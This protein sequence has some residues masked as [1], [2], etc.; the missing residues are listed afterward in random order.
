M[1]KQF[2]VL[3]VILFISFGFV[4]PEERTIVGKVTF[5]DNGSAL[6]GVNVILKSSRYAT[7]TDSQGNYLIKVPT[8]GG[9][10][11]FTFVGLKTN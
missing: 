6:P 9:T 1:K 2:S 11:V 7:V 8:T 10:L 5:A 3:I 4:A